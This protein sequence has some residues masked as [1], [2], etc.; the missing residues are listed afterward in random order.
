MKGLLFAWLLFVNLT[1]SAC[2][3]DPETV[4]VEVAA[5]STL[6]VDNYNEV[7]RVV[8]EDFTKTVREDAEV[9]ATPPPSTTTSII[10]SRSNPIPLNEVGN[11]VQIKENGDEIAFLHDRFR[12]FR[13]K[14]RGRDE[15]SST[16]R[17]SASRTI[18]GKR[19]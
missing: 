8:E 1:L 15:P 11:L 3:S 5:T 14:T 17:P 10:G 19:W 16:H 9:S 13:E 12:A 4:E 7:T 6:E 2:V 18:P